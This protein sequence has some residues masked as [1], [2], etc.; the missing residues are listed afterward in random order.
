MKL[1]RQMVPSTA[2]SPERPMDLAKLV[3]S[4]T[5]EAAPN[6]VSGTTGRALKKGRFFQFPT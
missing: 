1:A 5:Y 3:K 4:A 2:K 6:G